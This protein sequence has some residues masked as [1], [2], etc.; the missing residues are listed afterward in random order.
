MAQIIQYSLSTIIRGVSGGVLFFALLSTEAFSQD[1]QSDVGCSKS[2]LA[3]STNLQL[4][5]VIGNMAGRI[6][7]L[8]RQQL[9]DMGAGLFA[10]CGGLAGGA[11]GDEDNA[12]LSMG[13]LSMLALYDYSNQERDR[14]A[15]GNGFEQDSQ[16]VTVG[17]DYRLSAT[18][19]IG[20]TLSTSS[21][22]TTFDSNA[23]NQDGQTTVVA[24]HA[25]KYWDTFF[26]D[27]LLSVGR[28]ALDIERVDG[29]DRY[30]AS[31]DADFWSADISLGYGY[32]KDRWRLT[33]LSRLLIMR[34][35]IDAYREQSL[36]NSGVLRQLNSQELESSIFALSVQLDYIV[37]QNWGVLIP[38]VKLDYQRELASASTASGEQ[39]DAASNT[40][41]GNIAEIT[42]DPDS[43]TAIFGLG[44]S[45]QFQQGWSAYFNAE[46]LLGHEYL[47]QY[48]LVLGGRYEIP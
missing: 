26:V 43:N 23:G 30:Q 11:A 4:S 17:V 15:L 13:R 38:S 27:G 33:P 47:N 36:S 18:S 22:D 3:E 35:D 19:F 40:T 42:D 25:S 31:P 44:A 46:I 48:S 28:M 24:A 2:Q 37:P 39:I 45:A 29:V 12:L 7:G 10:S 14:T 8:R 41:T 20:T 6:G 9:C 1:C 32:S 21:A 34:G 16:S 5:N